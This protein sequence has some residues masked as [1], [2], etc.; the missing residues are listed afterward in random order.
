MK[1][2]HLRTEIKQTK[3]MLKKLE[4]ELLTEQNRCVHDFVQFDSYQQCQRC[5]KSEPLHY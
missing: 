5:Q 1:V 2:Q 4:N 3:I